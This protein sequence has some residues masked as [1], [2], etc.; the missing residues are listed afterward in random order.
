M[1]K[2]HLKLTNCLMY[3]Y[4]K[5]NKII[6]PKEAMYGCTNKIHV[7]NKIHNIKWNII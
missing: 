2:I 1:L 7:I 6:T 5:L 3:W 4:E